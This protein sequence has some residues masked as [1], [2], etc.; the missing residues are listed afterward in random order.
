MVPVLLHHPQTTILY[1]RI[2]CTLIT[3]GQ[4][5]RRPTK[6]HG[7]CTVHRTFARLLTSL[8]VHPSDRHEGIHA[9][10]DT[11]SSDGYE[12]D[13]YESENGQPI[14]MEW[15]DDNDNAEDHPDD[16]ELEGGSEGHS[17]G[18]TQKRFHPHLNGK[19]CR[20]YH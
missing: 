15:D 11:S 5:S 13:G 7:K 2:L 10:H 16:D 3:R 17:N 6:H 12:S 19:H 9:E 4:I 20:M 18:P 14:P 8:S 1:Q